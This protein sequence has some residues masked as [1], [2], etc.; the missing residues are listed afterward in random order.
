MVGAHLWLEKPSYI[1]QVSYGR[2]EEGTRCEPF[3]VTTVTVCDEQQ[4]DRRLHQHC[5]KRNVGEVV[6][7][8]AKGDGEITATTTVESKRQCFVDLGWGRREWGTARAI[9][10]VLITSAQLEFI[11]Y[12]RRGWQ[13]VGLLYR[14]DVVL[15][16][17]NRLFYCRLCFQRFVL[18]F[19]TYTCRARTHIF[20]SYIALAVYHAQSISPLIF[21]L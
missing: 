12:D 2:L 9:E 20:P 14:Y 4:F 5:R 13:R 10:E 3:A 16:C 17:P 7:N 19:R 8:S 11:R 1:V 6:A 18:V 21:A 15:S